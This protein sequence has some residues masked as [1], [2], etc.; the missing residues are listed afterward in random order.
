MKIEQVV[1][2]KPIMIMLETAKE[3]DTFW[4]LIELEIANDSDLTPEM[5]KMQID[6]SN[7]L[8]NKAHL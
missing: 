6:I 1:D 3:V 5:A 2:F 8:S 4:G 7:Y